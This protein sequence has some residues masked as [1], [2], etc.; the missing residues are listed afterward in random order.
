MAQ[1]FD[2]RVKVEES[3]VQSRF[4]KQVF[5]NTI[6][7]LLEK[8]HIE[9]DQPDMK[10]NL[11][12]FSEFITP[13]ST[14]LNNEW[15]IAQGNRK[16]TERRWLKDLRQYR[17]VYDPE[18]LNKM[19]PKRS[20]A[21][22][23]LTRSK[24]RTVDARLMDLQFPA[25]KEKN[26]AIEPT[27]VPQL[28]PEEL[29]KLAITYFQTVRKLPDEAAMRRVIMEAAR[30][31][32]DN[33]EKEIEDQLVEFKYRD[34]IRN[35]VHN[36]NLYGTGILKGPF[37][38][39]KSTKRWVKNAQSGDWKL[40]TEK[41]I[42]PV[43]SSVSVWDC[44]PDLSSKNPED[45]T[46]VFERH[47]MS[48]GKL[49]KLAKRSDF[50]R[51]A[52]LAYIAAHPDGDAE[53]KDW[54][55]L[56]REMSSNT[57]ADYPE[58]QIP[59][60][61]KFELVEYWGLMEKEKAEEELGFSLRDEDGFDDP[62]VVI[63]AWMLGPMIVKMVVSPIQGARFPYFFYY[64]D[65]DET[66][67]FGDGIPY[68]MRDPQALLNA[69]VRA[70][71]DNAAISAGPIIEANID[72]LAD[73]EDPNDVYPFRSFQRTGIGTD[74]S[75]QAVRITK[76][77]SYTNQFMA[78]VEFFQAAADESTNI[79]RAM[80]GDVSGGQG[81]GAA[82]RTAT[83]LSMLMGSANITLKDQL[84]NLDDFITKPFI[85]AL[86]FWNMEFNPK[87]DIKGDFSISARGSASLVAKE[88][89]LESLNQFLSII[90]ND[91]N[92]QLILK[93]RTLYEEYLKILDLDDVGLLKSQDEVD[94]ALE[95]QRKQQE[96]AENAQRQA[97]LLKAQSSGHVPG[98]ASSVIVD[99]SGRPALSN[100]DQ[101]RLQSG[102]LPEVGQSGVNMP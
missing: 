59:K 67:F 13:M 12:M 19:H 62:E 22:V 68:I 42:I 40:T 43:A 72:L 34:V 50:N 65:K 78:M 89:R 61:K 38:K 27:P 53:W 99:P 77:P 63:N 98:A 74:G 75:N 20:K 9:G 46:Y 93:Q 49:L 10:D 69:S 30:E 7:T 3:E 85:K 47:L 76:L 90:A 1:E 60:N 48:K 96:A 23:K 21:F 83:G 100:V 82:G 87:E 6:D 101:G 39:E 84:K 32:S 16:S 92:A 97:D 5:D 41:K 29:E 52:I 54:E 14:T 11:L 15:Q 44:F 37:V 17:G 51:R 25:N 26:W 57:L 66:H 86:Y 36:G 95:N 81:V 28:P 91:P 8:D 31:R 73:G 71:V 94:L 80:H 55:D 64:F 102:E 24:V 33:M 56:M 70:M 79:P 2:N 18:I 88:V 58:S 4:E 45:L 35:V